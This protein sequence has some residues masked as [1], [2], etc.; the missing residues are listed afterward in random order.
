M[1][2]VMMKTLVNYWEFVPECRNHNLVECFGDKLRDWG[3]TGKPSLEGEANSNGKALEKRAQLMFKI[4]FSSKMYN[5]LFLGS[6]GGG[7]YENIAAFKA[8][9]SCVRSKIRDWKLFEVMPSLDR[10]A[11][12]KARKAGEAGLDR[13]ARHRGPL[14]SDASEKRTQFLEECSGDAACVRGKMRD[15][16]KARKA[17]EASL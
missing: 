7:V 6:C 14:S 4:Y 1:I 5:R 16:R 17:G 3:K 13:R 9:M 10:R 12:R 2:R 8:G 11:R 15:W